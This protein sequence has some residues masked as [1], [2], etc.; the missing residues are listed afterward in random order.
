MKILYPPYALFIS[1]KHE[2]NTDSYKNVPSKGLFISTISLWIKF[3][4]IYF[5]IFLFFIY[6]LGSEYQTTREILT[7]EKYIFERRKWKQ[8]IFGE[9]MTSGALNLLTEMFSFITETVLQL[10]LN[11][12]LKSK[13]F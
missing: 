3:T 10:A 7:A 11:S 1:E 2:N 6:A 5:F 13:F 9:N 12:D 8:E 4:L